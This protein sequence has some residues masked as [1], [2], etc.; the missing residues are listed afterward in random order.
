MN[1]RSQ[2]GLC[3]PAVLAK[4]RDMQF[5]LLFAMSSTLIIIVVLILLGVTVFV[6]LGGKTKFSLELTQSA[7]SSGETVEGTI[8][9]AAGS[10]VAAERLVVTL[11]GM[12]EETRRK[13][14][15][16][17]GYDEND[18]EYESNSTE[19]FRH[20]EELPIELPVP[21]GFKGEIPFSFPA[22][23]GQ[24]V[25]VKTPAGGIKQGAEIP[26]GDLVG[27]GFASLNWTLTAALDGSKVEPELRILGITLG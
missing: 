23:W 20:E 4:I 17:V 7:Y 1:T 21:K 14:R 13:P 24:Q 22:P 2:I 18:D 5:P 15:S 25:S 27:G 10:N 9:V 6:V 12:Y 11:C 16:T 8:S 3:A 26:E 19:V